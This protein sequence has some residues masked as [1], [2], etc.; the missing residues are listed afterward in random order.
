MGLGELR[1]DGR[2]AI[3]TGAGGP[4]PSLGRTYALLL[5]SRGAKVVVNDLGVGP[6]SGRGVKSRA[7]EVAREIVDA[8]GEAV[9]DTNSVA[10]QSTAEAL[11]KRAIDTWGRVDILINNAGVTINAEFEEFSSGDIE[12][13]MGSHLMGTIWTSKAA[14]PYMRE[15]AYGRIVSASST[16]LLGYRYNS[17][18]GA[19]KA[20]IWSLMRTLA[21]EG[22][23]HGIKANALAPGA[24]TTAMLTETTDSEWRQQF[25]HRATPEKA[26]VV[27]AL[28]AHEQCPVS[29]KCIVAIAGRMS[30]LYLAQTTGDRQEQVTVEEVQRK[31]SAVIDRTA[32]FDHPDPV[33]GSNSVPVPWTRAPYEPS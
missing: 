15:A 17:V 20:G 25:M 19:A 13:V 1:F 29:G 23:D 18:Y 32:S 24:G 27:V 10:T 16:G 9:A 14:W 2:V 4:H 33:E 11:V 21:V 28:L 12:R 5:A 7:E 31:F 3:V 26:A 6:G 8:G 22:A 30:E